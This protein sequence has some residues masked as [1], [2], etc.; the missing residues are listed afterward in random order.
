MS[1]TTQQLAAV[2]AEITTIQPQA[3]EL[4]DQLQTTT[5]AEGKALKASAEWAAVE[6]WQ[7]LLSQRA[8]LR[9]ALEIEQIV[10]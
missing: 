8:Q 7:A 5:R 1:T 6:R 4:L 3:N 10:G 9:D 2:E